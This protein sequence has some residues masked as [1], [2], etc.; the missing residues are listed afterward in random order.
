MSKK[1][2]DNR[3]TYKKQI[4]FQQFID[5]TTEI[6][7]KYLRTIARLPLELVNG[8]SLLYPNIALFIQTNE[9]YILELFGSNE[10]FNGLTVKTHKEPNI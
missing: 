10:I 5:V 7:D 6:W 1:T 8:G 9:H 3:N 4:T 2:K